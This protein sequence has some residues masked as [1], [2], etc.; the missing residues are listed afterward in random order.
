VSPTT[1]TGTDLCRVTVVGPKRRVD[2]SL[3]YHV[4]FA[5]LF[6]AILHYAGDNLA[7]AGLA[8]GGWVLQR[9]DQPA[10][11]GGSTPAQ[12]NVRDGEVLYLRPAMSQLPELSFDDV[13]D[14]V[15]TGINEK[16]DRWRPEFTRSFTVSTTAGASLVAAAILLLSG[17]SSTPGQGSWILPAVA[18]GV[19]SIVALSAGMILSRVLGDSRSGAVLGFCALPYAFLAGLFGPA[20]E[21]PLVGLGAVHLLA[22]FAVVVLVGT[23]A[24]FGVADAM[25]T[26]FGIT[27]AAVMGTIGAAVGVL[28]DGV[29]AGGVAAVTVALTSCLTPLTPTIA[30]RLAKVSLPPVPQGPEDLRRDTMLVDGG[31]LLKRTAVADR[32][33]TGMTI[34]LGLV[35]ITAQIALAFGGG[36]AAPTMCGA[37][38][39]VLLLR[40]RVFRGRSQRLSLMVPGMAGLGVL[41]LALAAGSGRQAVA[42]AVLA[43][44]FIGGAIVSTVGIWL[45]DNRPS[46]VWGRLGD[47]IDLI[48]MI[49]LIPLALGVIGLFDYIR[50]L[51]G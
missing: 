42:M 10:F 8:H 3:P 14:V 45:T 1:G 40:S 37:V 31:Q 23:I 28:Y 15:A 18:A 21:T 34:A 49:S 5:Q 19:I 20:R 50:G 22:G 48:A 24:A 25:P 41:A 33:V 4:P 29:T 30:F 17:P 43:V 12:A 47:I 2:I 44:V 7:N 35:A 38:S 27:F 51:G 39:L 36:W 11:D 46:P 9:L 26:F 13:A 32:Y 6:P 16:S